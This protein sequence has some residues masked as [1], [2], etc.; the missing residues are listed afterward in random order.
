VFSSNEAS[1]RV[2][3]RFERLDIGYGGSDRASDRFLRMIRINGW[4]PLL[5]PYRLY[6]TSET[7]LAS[8][9]DWN[10]DTGLNISYAICESRE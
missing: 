6:F 4:M 9:M 7:C 5:I 3:W 1:L 10:V 2:H 8:D